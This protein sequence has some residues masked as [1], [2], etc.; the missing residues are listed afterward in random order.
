MKF[1]KISP[2][3]QFTS[4]SKVQIAIAAIIR[5]RRSHLKRAN[6]THKDYLDVGCGHN[7]HVD[8]I[9]LDYEWR[10]DIDICWDITKGIPLRQ[11]S[12]Q[13]IFTEHCLE[14]LPFTSVDFVIGEF[15]RVLK[16]KGS[17]RI[18]VPDGELYLTKYSDIIH[19]ASETK[20]PYAEGDIY[21][22]LYSPIM[23]VNR[24]FRSH[25][26]K[27]IYD[28]DTL[29]LLLEKNGFIDIKKESFHSG[30]DSRL[31]IDTESR[32]VESLYIEASKP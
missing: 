1:G 21:Q 28:F 5:N 20:L 31:I 3:R 26:H 6:V 15:R 16:S 10:P 27:F 17:V 22:G 25:G 30:R 2:D 29:R 12:V 13:G 23:S 24:I 8:F 32:A 4:Y 19:N 18:V 14:H 11:S 7:T 9:N